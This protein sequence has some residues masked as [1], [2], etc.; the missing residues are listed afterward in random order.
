MEGDGN[1]ELVA[2][3]SSRWPVSAPT[4]PK[5]Q[6]RVALA[7]AAKSAAAAWPDVHIPS[8][9]FVGYL[10][11]RADSAFAPLEAISRLALADLFLAC[12]CA[13]G[14][15]AADE[16]LVAEYGSKLRAIIG[17]IDPAPDFVDEVMNELHEALL[18]HAQGEGRGREGKITQYRG[19]ASLDVWLAASATRRALTRKGAAKPFDDLAEIAAAERSGNP[20]L[21]H[22]HLRYPNGFG[23][24]VTDGVTQAIGKMTS[25]DR[26]LLRSHLVEGFSLRKLS[27]I[28]GVNVNEVARNFAA[29]R[30]S[31]QDHI[32][33]VLCSRSG[34]ATEDA[35][36]V[37]SALFTRVNLG[38]VA[39]LRGLPRVG[40]S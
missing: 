21:D 10:A 16:A 34:L 36:A 18:G 29:V 9:P 35:D 6:L 2:M 1:S 39:A 8:E 40:P 17:A 25:N 13:R 26:L 19:R 33:A 5:G 28:R 20:D 11:E 15:A 23:Q 14:D 12:G 24:A 3:F 30:A 7:T 37:M 31:I 4:S 32:R 27:H 38:I 22:L